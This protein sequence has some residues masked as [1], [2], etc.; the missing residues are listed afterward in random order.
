MCVLYLRH[1]YRFLRWLMPYSHDSNTM[2]PFEYCFC[3]GILKTN[4]IAMLLL[5][6]ASRSMFL[7]HGPAS[8]ELFLFFHVCCAF[9]VLVLLSTTHVVM[10]RVV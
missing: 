7:D 10:P 2:K 3:A 1:A 6:A 5:D 8:A 4:S 9:S